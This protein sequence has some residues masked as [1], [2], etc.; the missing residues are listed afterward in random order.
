MNQSS[1]DAYPTKNS[2][3]TNSI[4]SNIKKI[5]E[6]NENKQNHEHT[7]KTSIVEPTLPVTVETLNL[8]PRKSKFNNKLSI[9]TEKSNV[10]DE[11]TIMDKQFDFQK[12]ILLLNKRP[13]IGC[14]DSLTWFIDRMK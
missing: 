8:E 5:S 4:K 6:N 12:S 11:M 10:E 3:K 14:F 9:D 13:Y 7:K 1:Q 2:I